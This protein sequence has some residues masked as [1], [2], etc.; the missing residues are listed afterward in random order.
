MEEAVGSL[1]VLT[2]AENKKEKPVMKL[3][4]YI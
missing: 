4:E 3:Y 1:L 2:V